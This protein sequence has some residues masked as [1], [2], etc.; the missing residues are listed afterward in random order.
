MQPKISSFFKTPS[1]SSSSA[2]KSDDPPP[3]YDDLFRDEVTNRKEPEIRIT[4]Q[5]RR[6]PNP[7][8]SGSDGGSV[9]DMPKRADLGDLSSKPVPSLSRKVLNKKRSYAQ[10]H[11]ELG[12]S[13]FL[14]HS[15]TT[16]GFKY[17][18]GDEG[19]EK[20]HKTFHK[21]YTHGIQFKGW[22]NE[23]EIQMPALKGSRIILVLEDDPAHQRN[24]VQEVVKMMEMEL[25]E[26][27]IFHKHCKVYLFVESQR[28]AGCLVAEQIKKAYKILSSSK[29]GGGH[30]GTGAKDARPDSTTLQFGEVIFQR[31]VARKATSHTSYEVLE[32]NRSGAIFCEEETVPARCGIRAI[33]VSPCNRRKHIAIHLLDAARRSFCMEVVLEHSQLAFSQP[34]SAGKA[35][36][37]TYTGTPSFLVYKASDSDC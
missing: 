26:E 18:A 14:L 27:W 5:R 24:K 3:V 31:E 6:P 2:P 11:L 37:S 7:P 16:C 25:G 33:W 34:T 4:Y 20:V 15:C 21:D 9:G 35:L 17:A 22:R 19:D 12:Q 8:K 13:D 23:R 32:G 36:A 10:F 1:D 29:G 28:I 30:K